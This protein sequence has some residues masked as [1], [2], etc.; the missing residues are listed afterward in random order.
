VSPAGALLV[1]TAAL[2]ALG[3]IAAWLLNVPAWA[4]AAGAVAFGW[5]VRRLYVRQRAKRARQETEA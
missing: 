1:S 2:I 5:F 3:A 4:I